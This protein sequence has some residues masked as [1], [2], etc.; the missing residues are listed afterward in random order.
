MTIYED[1]SV[2]DCIICMSNEK[3]TVFATCGHYVCCEE[4]S[5]VIYKTT[6]KCP[7]CRNKI[8]SVVKREFIQVS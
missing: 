7:M 6:R 8:E 5:D 1:D 3:N 4:C 2:R